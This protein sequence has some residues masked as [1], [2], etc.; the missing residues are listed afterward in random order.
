MTVSDRLADPRLGRLNR[1][2]LGFR[3]ALYVAVMIN[4]FAVDPGA[5][6]WL[7]AVL[8]VLMLIP[9]LPM[10][11]L[12]DVRVEVGVTI[13]LAVSFVLWWQYGPLLAIELLPINAVTV[14]GLLLPRRTARGILIFALGLQLAA[15]AAEGVAGSGLILFG[16]PQSPGALLTRTVIGCLVAGIGF[17]FLTVGAVLRDYQNEIA[18]R[19]RVEV[20]LT[21]VVRHKNSLINSVAHELRTPLTAV[22]GFSQALGDSELRLDEADRRAFARTV[23][24]ES[25][26]LVN[27]VDNLI[28]EA[29]V[30]VNGL[31]SSVE[32]L[33][34]DEELRAIWTQVHPAEGWELQI[35]GKGSVRAD[36]HRLRQL[37]TNLLDNALSV[38]ASPLR[39]AITETSDRLIGEF[40]NCG[41]AF[42]EPFGEYLPEQVP[43]VKGHTGLGLRAART[44]AQ[45]MS[46]DLHYHNGT[47]VLSLPSSR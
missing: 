8:V 26:R 43:T 7:V 5:P 39:V 14:S 23:A 20:R 6:M 29:R 47:F 24:D 37:L 38:G 32:A 28:V 35:E 10:P 19:S 22:F 2:L 44:L 33:D 41:A 3:V 45:A 46:G 9:A 36:R 27:V 18:E 15:L 21:E 4:I 12:R 40:E 1:G 42:Q 17:G 11:L 16:H 13:S 34:L 25:R 30:K 31:V